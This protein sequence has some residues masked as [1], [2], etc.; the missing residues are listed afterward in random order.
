MSLLKIEQVSSPKSN[1]KFKK[2]MVC[3]CDTCDCEF[4]RNYSKKQQEKAIEYSFCSRKCMYIAASP[5]GIVDKKKK[6]TYL[7]R[8]GVDHSSKNDDVMKKITQKNKLT[9]LK[10]YGTENFANAPGVRQ[11]I[12][13]TMLEKY[14]TAC[15]LHID[16]VASR[17]NAKKTSMERY[18][19][20]YPMQSSEIQKKRIQT[21]IDRYG[22]EYVTQSES[23]KAKFKMIFQ[24]RYGVDNPLQLESVRQKIKLTCIDRYDTEFASQSQEAKE[25]TKISCFER[26][27]VENQMQNDTIKEKVK[28][29]NIARYGVSSFL[30]TPEVRKK[31]RQINGV[32]ISKKE[33]AFFERL[34]Q[35]FKKVDRHVNITVGSS[36]R[37]IDYYIHDIDCYVSYNGIYWH[38]KNKSDEELIMTKSSQSEGIRRTKRYDAE[39]VEWANKNMKRFIVIWEGEEDKGV[40]MFTMINENTHILDAWFASDPLIRKQKILGINEKQNE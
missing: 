15:S 12:R 31:V 9:C 1:R 30:H 35:I 39:L 2:I 20:E 40:E 18:G 19:V 7:D 24:A 13:E 17:E 11:K 32:G 28:I 14:G 16:N 5:G 25:A 23:F 37:E 36:R 26:F 33:T 38:G 10:K 27:G 34:I 3:Q 4:M 29:T 6:A 21:C 8:Y 22:T